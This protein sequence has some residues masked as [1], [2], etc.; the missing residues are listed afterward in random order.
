MKIRNE[1]C[2]DESL[3]VA[4]KP[5]KKMFLGGVSGVLLRPRG[6]SDPH[7][8]F[9]IISED[10]GFWFP[11]TGNGAS[12]S[13]FDDTIAVLAAAKAWCEQNAI[14]DVHEGRQYGWIFME[15]NP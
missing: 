5:F 6:V 7:I 4:F 12:S 11:Y 10:D 15:A 1:L 9:E 3:S 8:C 2:E 14:P 13:W